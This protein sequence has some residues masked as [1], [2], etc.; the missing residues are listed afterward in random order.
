MSIVLSNIR[1]KQKMRQLL[2][3]AS[4]EG[5]MHTNIVMKCRTKHFT[6]KEVTEILEDWRSRGLIDKYYVKTPTSKKPITI[7]RANRNIIDG[8]L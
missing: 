3:A 5:M 8:R 6:N 4:T 1:L 2:M 7:W